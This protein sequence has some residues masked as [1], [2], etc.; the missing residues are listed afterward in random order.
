[1]GDIWYNAHSAGST[2]H[3]DRRLVCI[4]QPTPVT[5]S[6]TPSPTLSPT[7]EASYG[8]IIEWLKGLI[9]EGKKDKVNS[10]SEI[11]RTAQ[12]EEGEAKSLMDEALKKLNEAKGSWE[13]C[14]RNYNTEKKRLDT[15]IDI[16]ARTKTVLNGL[17]NGEQPLD[18]KEV[19]ALISLADKANPEK[20]KEII[21]L[22]QKLIDAANAELITYKDDLDLCK[23]ALESAEAAYSKAVGIWEAASLAVKDKQKDLDAAQGELTTYTKYASERTGVVQD[24]IATMEN[25]ISLLGQLLE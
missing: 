18:T 19:K 20:V 8:N 4:S 25:I 17:L 7:E 1:M 9:A 12:E 3:N 14:V 5:P 22:V 6:P 11:L 2:S 24:E 16:F 21:T 10:S 13:V 15:E 23:D